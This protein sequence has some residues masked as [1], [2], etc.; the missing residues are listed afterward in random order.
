MSQQPLITITKGK[1]KR[2]LEEQALLQYNSI[3]KKYLDKGYKKIDMIE[4]IDLEK[5]VPKQVTDTVGIA[6]PML[7]KV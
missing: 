6:K 1:V 7:C 2:T 4:E 5:V 3:I